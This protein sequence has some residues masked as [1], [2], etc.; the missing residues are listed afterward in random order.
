[1]SLNPTGMVSYNWNC[2]KSDRDDYSLELTGT[3]VSLQETQARQFNPNGGPGAPRFWDNGDPVFN[4]R[5]GLAT[6]NGS[7]KSITMAKA[8]KAQR[9]GKKPSLHMQLFQV[10]GGRNISELIGKTIHIWTWPAHPQTGQVWGQGNPRL[11]G[12][13]EIPNTKY[14][15]ADPLPDEFKV[16]KLLCDDGASG[17]QPVPQAPQYMQ[18]PQ[19]V[20]AYQMPPQQQYVAPAPMP[21]PAPAPV[22]QRVQYTPVQT[23]VTQ[24]VGMDPAVAQAMQSIPEQVPL[25]DD[26]EF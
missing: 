15:L 11:F 8:G 26:I 3:V 12:V 1:M 2:T 17:G 13:E 22:P 6:Q 16:P 14:E 7:L 10:S 4:I 20:P 25:Y 24:P 9:E 18:V 21:A 23:T 19:Q 5:V